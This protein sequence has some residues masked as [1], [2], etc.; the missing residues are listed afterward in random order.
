[1]NEDGR[2]DERTPEPGET[3]YHVRRA[4][5]GDDDS[6]TWI[7]DRFRPLLSE[8]AAMKLGK[9]LRRFCDPEDLVNEAWGIALPKLRDLRS[10]GEGRSTPVVVRYLTGTITRLCWNLM[11]KHVIGKPGSVEPDEGQTSVVTPDLTDPGAGVMTGAAQNETARRVR[12]A[13][14][15]LEHKDR[16]IVLLRGIEQLS[17]GEVA[18][19][20]SIAK[21]T[22]AVRYHRALKRLREQVPDS[23]YA[24]LPD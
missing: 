11:R 14:Q 3:T 8:F 24:E 22:V 10:T 20:L 13:L 5:D 21:G 18:E 15:Q 2:D 6:V 12:Q 17:N 1:M 16:E 23:V 7:V 9:S 19:Q 4:K